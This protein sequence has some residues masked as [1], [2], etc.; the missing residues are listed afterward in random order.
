MT[1]NST[2]VCFLACTQKS[3]LYLLCTAYIYLI[4]TQCTSNF[5]EN[6]LQSNKNPYPTHG[7]AYTLVLCLVTTALPL[8]FAP[9]N[10]FPPFSPHYTIYNDDINNHSLLRPGHLVLSVQSYFLRKNVVFL[11][12]SATIKMLLFSSKIFVKFIEK[13]FNQKLFS[14]KK[15]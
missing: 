7:F 10:S 9:F 1:V 13:L 12:F 2:H 5:I 6:P 3:C 4:F 8:A 14:K 15:D 11:L